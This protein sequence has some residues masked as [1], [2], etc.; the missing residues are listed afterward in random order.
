MKTKMLETIELLVAADVNYITKNDLEDA[1]KTD[2][3]ETCPDWLI[4][5][6][7]AYIDNN[8][9]RSVHVLNF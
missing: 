5:W 3:N 4:S 2:H 1:Y 7:V 6:A 8:Y 9:W